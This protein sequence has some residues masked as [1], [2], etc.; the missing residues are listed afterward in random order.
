M[1]AKD[2][3][4]PLLHQLKAPYTIGDKREIFVGDTIRLLLS[5]DTPFH[6][7]VTVSFLGA[8]TFEMGPT[9]P[10]YYT[11]SCIPYTT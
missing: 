7:T 11:L 6:N 3:N 10:A 8:A 9:D 1:F 2:D 5:K 4:N